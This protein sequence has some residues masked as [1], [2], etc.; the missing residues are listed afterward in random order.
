MTLTPISL[1]ESARKKFHE[2][3]VHHVWNV[4]MKRFWAQKAEMTLLH[5][6]SLESPRKNF[7]INSTYIMSRK[8]E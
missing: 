3:D 8:W 4:A 5:I 6:R 7:F 2:R 1:H